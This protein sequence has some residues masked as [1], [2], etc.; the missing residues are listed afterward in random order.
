MK[1]CFI[2]TAYI[3][4]NLAGLVSSREPDY[5]ICADG[6]YELAVSQGIVPDLVIGDSDSGAMSNITGANTEFIHFPTEKDESDTFLCIKHALSLECDEIV[7]TG[8]IGGRLDHTISNIQTLACFANTS[9]RISVIDDKNYFTV[10]E[11]SQITLSGN[12]DMS[13]SIFSLTDTCTGV[14]TAGLYYPLDNAVLKSTYP[15]GLSNK[16]TG[17]S[18]SIEVKKGKLLIVMSLE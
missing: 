11:N 13:V 14:S 15:V 9:Q 2:I 8:G 16:F 10:I 5:I 17:C 1:T 18:A 3:E 6:G 4:G 12:I 7:I